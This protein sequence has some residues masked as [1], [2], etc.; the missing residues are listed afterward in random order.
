MGSRTSYLC[1]VVAQGAGMPAHEL[2]VN[3]DEIVMVAPFAQRYSVMLSGRFVELTGRSLTGT[4]VVG[5]GARY[6]VV[7]VGCEVVL[8]GG[9]GWVLVLDDEGPNVNQPIRATAASSVKTS[10]PTRARGRRSAGRTFSKG[11]F[12]A[13]HSS[14]S[15]Q[16]SCG[17]PA[18]SS[19]Q[20]GDSGFTDTTV[21]GTGAGASS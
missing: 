18:G 12:N 10:D 13:P 15:N 14:P 16:R 1:A 20:P 4:V 6:S 2:N 11:F 5:R 19:Y 17:D 3:C 7:D 21:P 8:D 9:V